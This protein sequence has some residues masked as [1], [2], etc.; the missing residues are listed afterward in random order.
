MAK[1]VGLVV[2]LALGALGLVIYVQLDKPVARVVVSGP[3]GDAERTE[4]REVVGRTIE[5]GLLSADL[6]SI[7]AAIMRLSWPRRV[8]IRRAW[9]GSLEIRVEKPMVVARW[10]DAYMSSDGQIVR[11]PGV[12]TDLPVFDCRISEPRLAMEIFHRLSEASSAHGLAISAVEESALGEWTLTLQPEV[13]TGREIASLGA[14]ADAEPLGEF[15]LA[16]GASMLT[17]RLERFLV[18]Y[19]QALAAR[20][21]EIDRVDARYDNG[22]AVSWI[23]PDLMARR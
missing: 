17:E 4:V 21:G 11:L 15:D 20:S 13:E 19:D 8:A 6:G 7:R 12:R 1:L 9:P 3:L 14:P 22:V 16:L 23:T 18:V 5:G 2:V 10:Q